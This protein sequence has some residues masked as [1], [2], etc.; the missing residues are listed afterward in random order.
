MGLEE[1]RFSG[2]G[3]MVWFGW[4]KEENPRQKKQH[5]Q[6]IRVETK[7]YIFKQ[8]VKRRDKISGTK[9]KKQYF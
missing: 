7:Q 1:V 2:A 4:V 8:S 6:K 5:K 3:R 9:Y